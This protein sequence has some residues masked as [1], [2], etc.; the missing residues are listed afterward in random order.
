MQISL[1]CC[2]CQ[3]QTAAAAGG[4]WACIREGRGRAGRVLDGVQ[5]LTALAVL[6]QL[7]L[8]NLVGTIY[9]GNRLPLSATGSA[10]NEGRTTQGSSFSSQPTPL[11][12][13]SHSN[14]HSNSSPGNLLLLSAV[15]FFAASTAD[16]AARPALL[17]P[18]LSWRGHLHL[19]LT[20]LLVMAIC[21][22]SPASGPA[23]GSALHIAWFTFWPEHIPSSQGRG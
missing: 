4:D 6:V 17:C 8:H 11:P 5:Q 3:G 10:C 2:I 13:H 12:T 19:H 23:A 21:K 22:S 20:Y 9:T 16:D 18:I 14:S 7:M 15:W 1:S